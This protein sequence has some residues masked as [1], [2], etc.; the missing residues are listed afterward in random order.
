MAGAAP[1]ELLWTGFVRRGR[2]LP[3]MPRDAVGAPGIHSVIEWSGP[4]REGLEVLG[5]LRREVAPR[6]SSL[7]TV[8]FQ[9]LQTVD[10]DEFRHGLYSYIK[11][12]FTDELSPELIDIV[13]E[14][15]RLLGSPLTQIELLGMGGA[16]AEVPAE[17]TAFAHRDARWLVN[18]L[19]VWPDPADSDAEIAWSRATHAAIAPLTTGGA[20]VNFMEGDEESSEWTA[21]GPTLRR[22]QEIKAVYDPE[23]LFRLNQNIRPASPGGKGVDLTSTSAWKVTR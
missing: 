7:A 19:A 12:S 2:A 16:I 6:A 11:A 21:Y 5:G 9:Q 15:G 17:R 13:V 23:N 18:I 4:V 10:D 3:W 8:P 20:Y 14:R 1:D 22:L